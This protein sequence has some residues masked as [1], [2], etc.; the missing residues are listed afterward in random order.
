MSARSPARFAHEDYPTLAKVA[1][2]SH[3]TVRLSDLHADAGSALRE[4]DHLRQQ[5]EDLGYEIKEMLERD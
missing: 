2:Y 3:A 4:I 5:I 1:Q